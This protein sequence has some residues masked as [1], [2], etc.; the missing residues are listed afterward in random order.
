MIGDERYIRI[1]FKLILI[2]GGFITMYLIS[3]RNI[4]NFQLVINALAIYRK[5]VE[6]RKAKM[7]RKKKIKNQI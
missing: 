1:L 2:D 4:L 6:P 5:V 7:E 3:P